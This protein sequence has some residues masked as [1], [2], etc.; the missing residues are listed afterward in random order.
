MATGTGGGHPAL[1]LPSSSFFTP[2]SSVSPRSE[3]SGSSR[4]TIGSR[5]LLPKALPAE[6]SSAVLEAL[7]RPHP[8][9]LCGALSLPSPSASF[10]SSCGGKTCACCRRWGPT[11]EGQPN[12][13]WPNYRSVDWKRTGVA[14]S[15]WC[16]ECWAAWR[17]ALWRERR[18][19]WRTADIDHVR[20]Q[21]IGT[22]TGQGRK[23][24]AGG[25][26]E[27]NY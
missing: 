22:W 21:T 17:R 1:N 10:C 15:W 18:E 12:A 5:A 9:P 6:V 23:G 13:L 24:G 8:C 20:R 2:D 7:P 19:K 14:Q 11:E 4:S 3:Y 27:G 16:G 25:D 26:Y